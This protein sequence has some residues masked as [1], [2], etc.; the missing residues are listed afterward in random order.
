MLMCS[1][2]KVEYN[3]P[4]RSVARLVFEAEQDGRNT[5]NS[6][7]GSSLKGGSDRAKGVTKSGSGGA[8]GHQLQGRLPLAPADLSPPLKIERRVAAFSARHFL[9]PHSEWF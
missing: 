5:G 9:F 8:G 2:E 4:S 1:C 6:S 3:I 7:N